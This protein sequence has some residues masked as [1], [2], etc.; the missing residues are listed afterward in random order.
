M[1]ERCQY[2]QGVCGIDERYVCYAAAGPKCNIRENFEKKLNKEIQ[3]QYKPIGVNINSI[4][5][6]DLEQ[7]E[8]LIRKSRLLDKAEIQKLKDGRFVITL[9]DNIDEVSI[10]FDEDGN[11]E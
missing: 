10:T 5:Q 8:A 2:Y 9:Y 1:I 4:T 6:T 7:F 11:I 3:K